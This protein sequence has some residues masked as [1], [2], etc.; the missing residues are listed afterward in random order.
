MQARASPLARIL[1]KYTS[2]SDSNNGNYAV[3][4]SDARIALLP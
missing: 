4:S 2:P 3:Q 1:Q